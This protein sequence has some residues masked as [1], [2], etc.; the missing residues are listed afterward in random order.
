MAISLKTI[1]YALPMF[2]TDVSTGT[3]YTDSSDRVIYIPETTSRTFVSVFLE[4][5]WHDQATATVNMSGWGVRGSCD[6]GTNWTSLTSSASITSTAENI[7]YHVVVD[8]TN[9]FSNRFGSGSTG[10][11]RYGFYVNY[12]SAITVTNVSAKLYITYSY[13]T[14]DNTRIKTVRIPIESLNGRLSNT[15]QIV[16]QGSVTGQIPNLTGTGGFLPE[17]NVNIRQMFFELYTKTYPSSTTDASL[18]LKIDSGGNETTFGRVGNALSSP[19][20][21]RFLYDVTSII[22]DTTISHDLYARHNAASGLY[23]NNLGGWLTI[24]YEYNESNT[25]EVLNSLII[26][27]ESDYSSLTTANIDSQAITY[28]LNIQEP[29]TVTLKQSGMFILSSA[30]V[31][32]ATFYFKVGTQSYVTYN[33]GTGSGNTGYFSLMHRFDSGGAS[34][35]GGISLSR[36]SNFID[37]YVYSA[38]AFSIGDFIPLAII[39]YTSGKYNDSAYHNHTVYKF[40]YSNTGVISPGSVQGTSSVDTSFNLGSNY[41]LNN[42]SFGLYMTGF[43]VS[44]NGYSFIKL[45]SSSGNKPFKSALFSNTIYSNERSTLIINSN[46]TNLFKQPLLPYEQNTVGGFDILYNNRKLFYYSN[47]SSQY[48]I[49]MYVTY[50]QI[51]Y[52][53]SGNI[54]GYD[55]SGNPVQLKLFYKYTDEN[56]NTN[57]IH[58]NSDSMSYSSYSFTVH[59]NTSEY[60]VEAWQDSTRMGRSDNI[61]IT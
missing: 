30:G 17:A 40:I 18:V 54:T 61:T 55:G 24:T 2:T 11:F 6:S 50:H 26:T 19:M 33:S 7:P 16:R 47:V 8:M 60:F 58:I 15:A 53:I 46:C 14:N 10:T 57:Y 20:N 3:T 29:S 1:E 36:G 22:S 38:I 52:T 27:P 44:G 21:L 28:K 39:N 42:V 37:C 59:D 43:S 5:M 25:T 48:F 51:N 41:F 31:S 12:A 9:E 49:L 32:N 34:G 13:D 35:S 4:V 56:N 45:Q 23:F